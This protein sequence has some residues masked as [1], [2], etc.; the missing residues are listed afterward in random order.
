MVA[1]T[2][3]VTTAEKIRRLPW[4][5]AFHGL[6]SVYAT[7]TFFGSSFVL[8]LSELGATNTHIGFLLALMPFTGI[9]AVFIAPLVGR[10]GYKRTYVTFFGVRK[11]F[12]A[13]L[14]LVP[15]V[16]AQ[17]GI[18]AALALASFVT[19]GFALSRSIAETGYYPWIQDIIPDS[20]RGKH[21][22]VN[23]MVSRV[24]SIAAVAFAG[25]ILGLST[26]I[27]RFVVLFTVALFF[28]VAAVWSVAHLPGG[29]PG[30]TQRVSF[31]RFGQVLRDRNFL[32]YIGGLG[33][34]SLAGAPLAFIPIFMSE[35][36]GLSDSSVVLLQIGSITGGLSV[37]YLLGWAADRYGSK[38]IMLWGLTAKA[39]L[40]IGWL[41]MPRNAELSL[42]IAVLIAFIWGV[43]EIAWALGSGRLLFTR[44]VPHG[45][46]GAYMAVFYSL[47]GLIGGISQI[48]SGALLD[49]TAGVSGEV[50]G[51]TLDPFTPLFVA[52]AVLNF[53]SLLIL[54]GVRADS[55]VS[56]IDFAGMFLHGNPVLALQNVMRYHR[57]TDERTTVAVT[58]RMGHTNS[59]LA[60]DELLTALSDPRFNVRFEAI[61]A[62]SHMA[63]PDPR[64][65][66]ALCEMLDSG[67]ELAL[68]AIAAWGLGRIGDP[69]ALPSLR[70]SLDS[71][72]RSI[73]SH[74][75]RALGMLNDTSVGET[76]LARL[77]QETDKGLKMAFASAL[78][79][80][81][82]M[83]AQS[84]LFELLKETENHGARLELALALAR[85][86]NGESAFIRLFRS[87]RTDP[88]T[89]LSQALTAL[90]RPL[91]RIDENLP[92]TLETCAVSFAREHFD[93]AVQQLVEIIDQCTTHDEEYR[94][95][96]QEC[97]ARL[98]EF[99]FERHEYALLALT[100]LSTWP[101]HA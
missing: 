64:L 44:V 1:V 63:A 30:S 45:Q 35:Q 95:A 65:V 39:L 9:V 68:S 21:S 56:V 47:V 42:P 69:A 16:I 18:G 97:S 2:V 100:L 27:D 53:T 19:F 89:S 94:H 22:A 93:S 90:K 66:E 34:A 10:F 3:E 60:A 11:V 92:A 57:A 87:T 85:L 33:T 72:W 67:T 75:T 55:D 36:V 7:L 96:L 23:D 73:Q 83:Q 62:I 88:G 38:P 101:A 52:S 78:G 8:F 29:A 14:L 86:F 46:R 98:K 13:L 49:T 82:Y 50:L 26:G 84:A 61:Y 51:F 37:T 71:P 6:N 76:L 31:R 4:N 59:P 15:W 99:G 77:P 70:R 40:P 17:Y 25:Y 80:M 20:V 74:A 81:R 58:D 41:I 28:G 32:R 24:V 5:I 12:T 79:Q 48:L 91:R 43:V 54:R